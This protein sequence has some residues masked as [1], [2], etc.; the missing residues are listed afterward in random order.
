MKREQFAQIDNF[1]YKMCYVNQRFIDFES[2]NV[3]I[4]R[5]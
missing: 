5:K 1:I 4:L 2:A 3:Y